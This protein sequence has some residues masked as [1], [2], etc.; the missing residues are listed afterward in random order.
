MGVINWFV[1]SKNGKPPGTTG[2]YGYDLGQSWTTP[3]PEPPR[4][5]AEWLRRALGWIGPTDSRPIYTRTD[6]ELDREKIRSGPSGVI[7]PW[8]LPYFDDQT[9]ETVAMRLAYRRMLADPNVKAAMLGKLLGVASLDLQVHPAKKQDAKDRTVAE[10]VQ[11]MLTE[12]TKGGIPELAWNVLSGA[13][14]DGFSVSEKVWGVEDKG[15][16]KGRYVLRHLKPKDT[17][18]DLVLEVDEFRNVVGVKTLRNNAGQIY[19]PANFLIYAHLPMY[20]SPAG[21][22]DFRA[23]Y[24]R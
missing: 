6:Q 13:L 23:V 15:R 21:A 22:S 24:S 1:R 10:F 5:L 19:A 14:V 9:G 11:W 4:G 17:Y 16:Y 20:G 3:P 18:R 8:F 12:R 7:L 2:Q